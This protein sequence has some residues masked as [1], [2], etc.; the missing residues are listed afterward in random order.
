MKLV[1]FT[2]SIQVISSIKGQIN[3]TFFTNE[4]SSQSWSLV[5]KER[6]KLNWHSVD[7]NNRRNW[8][9][10][11]MKTGLILIV[12]L[13]W[14]TIWVMMRIQS[15]QR[16]MQQ[17][18]IHNI[19][20]MKK[21]PIWSKQCHHLKFEIENNFSARFH[22][23]ENSCVDSSKSRCYICLLWPIFP[24]YIFKASLKVDNVYTSGQF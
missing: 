17:M 19:V 20:M 2:I 12:S 16:S 1:F 15:Y 21:C 14:W 7:F 8:D 11:P 22:N 5:T 23:W 18:T 3:F 9:M 13:R 6:A 24:T 10:I 4:D